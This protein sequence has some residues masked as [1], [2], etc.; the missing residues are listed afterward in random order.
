MAEEVLLGLGRL[1]PMLAG[2]SLDVEEEGNRWQL[3]ADG[4][5]QQV[6]WAVARE[7]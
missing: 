4:N 6:R 5:D 3:P 2:A 1:E 7:R